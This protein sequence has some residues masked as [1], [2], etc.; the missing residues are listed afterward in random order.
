MFTVQKNFHIHRMCS[1]HFKNRKLQTKQ[2]HFRY[3]INENKTNTHMVNPLAMC[4]K[5]KTTHPEVHLMMP[6]LLLPHVPVSL[7]N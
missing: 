4:H 6:I 5:P 2:K 7:Y 1:Q 3:K